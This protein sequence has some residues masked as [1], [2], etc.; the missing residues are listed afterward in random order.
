MTHDATYRFCGGYILDDSGDKWWS[1]ELLAR[2]ERERDAAQTRARRACQIL[3]E[4]TG[5]DGPI[6]VDTAAERAAALIRELRDQV[7]DLTAAQEES[8]HQMHMRIRSGYDKTIAD[9]WRAAL[10]KVER[11]R[12]VLRRVYAAASEWLTRLGA[13]GHRYNDGVPGELMDA[14]DA[15]EEFTKTTTKEQP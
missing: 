9:A 11:E 6:D 10:A 7:A 13:S 4:E 3:V 15:Y 1:A 2:T 12:D 5:A 8:E 14:V